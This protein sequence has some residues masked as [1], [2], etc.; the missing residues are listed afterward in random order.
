MHVRLIIN[1][2]KAGRSD[3]RAA[4]QAVRATGINVEVRVTW[5]RGDGG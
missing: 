4:V 1:G 2:K 5:E 3:V